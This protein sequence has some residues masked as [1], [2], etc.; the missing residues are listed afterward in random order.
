MDTVK[1][2]EN[3]IEKILS[4][5]DV[6]NLPAIPRILIDLM[7]AIRREDVDIAHLVKLIQQDASLSASILA[8]A[9][10][11]DF[12]Q[13]KD[14]VD[15]KH[16]IVARGLVSIKASIMAKVV[17][18]FFAKIPQN[19][20]YYLEILW[21]RSLN[22][23]YLARQ[24]AKLTGYEFP[25]EAYLVGLIHRLGQLI[26]LQCYPIDYPEFLDNYLDAED[27][28][29]EKNM[30]GATH[31]EIGAYVIATWPLQSLISDAVL[32]QCKSIDT[33][34]DSANLVKVVNLASRLSCLDDSNKYSILGQANQLYGLNQA[35]IET[36]M[37]EVKPMVEQMSE[38][39]GFALTSTENNKI[40][41]MTR[42][43]QREEVQAQLGN[44]VKH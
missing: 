38:E 12:R 15:L 28:H 6:N 44:R 40:S 36:M 23:A 35:I 5:I 1:H 26:L 34:A 4:R 19:Q 22:C 3:A 21:Y 42:P 37:A 24:L 17:Q 18:Q 27:E 8:V 11:P 13:I 32:Y 10:R 7:S 2:M 20:Q 16:I 39:L 9:K 41:N 14:V 29:A 25:D 30:F 31:Y 43:E 33:I